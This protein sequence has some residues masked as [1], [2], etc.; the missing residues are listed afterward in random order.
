MI[1]AV[2]SELSVAD[3]FTLDYSP[4]FYILY[5]FFFFFFYY[6]RMP[7]KKQLK[8]E[9]VGLGSQFEGIQSVHCDVHSHWKLTVVGIC[10]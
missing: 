5:C 1:G 4:V 10:S 6:G 9:R 8:G 7:D 2:L 3:T